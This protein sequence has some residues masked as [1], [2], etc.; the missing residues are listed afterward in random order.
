MS[1]VAVMPPVTESGYRALMPVTALF[2]VAAVNSD[3]TV[4]QDVTFA[5]VMVSRSVRFVWL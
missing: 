1:P 2:S 4:S 5:W 3:A